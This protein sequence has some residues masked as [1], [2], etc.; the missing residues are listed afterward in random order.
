MFLTKFKED[1]ME[2]SKINLFKCFS[3]P[4]MKF[5]LGKGFRYELIAIDPSSNKKFWLFI[6]NHNVSDALNEWSIN[7]PNKK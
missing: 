6:K 5:L 3:V 2:N 7:N 1:Y 4:L